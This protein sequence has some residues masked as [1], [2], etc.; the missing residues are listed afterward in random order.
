MAMPI[1][2]LPAGLSSILLQSRVRL[3]APAVLAAVLAGCG[4]DEVVLARVGDA[5]ITE[6]GLER[7]VDR[8]PDHLVSD[9][10]GVEADR[11][12]LES[13]V[14]QELLLLEARN[15]GLDTTTALVRQMEDEERAYLSGRFNSQVI[16]PRIEVGPKEIERAFHDMG[17][18]RERLLQRIVVRGSERDA[19]DVFERLKS[20]ADFAALVREHAANDARIDSTGTIGWVGVPGLKRLRVPQSEFLSLP[21]GTPALLPLSPLVW[22]I[23]RFEQDR[24]VPIQLYDDDVGKLLYRE[25]WWRRTEEEVELLR[26]NQDV[27]FH[28]EG[29]R[30]LIERAEARQPELT[31]EQAGQPLFTWA[32]GNPVTA[33]D[34]V[35]RVRKMARSSAVADSALI[36]SIAERELLYPRL[37]AFEARERGWHEDEAFEEWWSR[38]RAG[39]L[40]DHL[41]KIEVEDRLV[42]SEEDVRAY[43]EANRE[44]FRAAETARIEE[45]HAKDEALAKDW[46]D[47]IEAGT[48]FAEI[49]RRPGTASHGIHKRGG[50]MILQPHL[51]ESFP[52]LVEAAFSAPLGEL[53]GPLYLER[54]DSHAILRVLEREGSR[55]RTFDEARPAV[56]HHLRTKRRDSLV[57]G[58][59]ESLRER[60]GDRIQVFEDRLEQ[61]HAK[62]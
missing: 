23:I 35:D 2:E 61:R 12:H 18:D 5:E 31:P 24:E 40:L 52:E 45:V 57:S 4:P 60:Y 1:P 53:V 26:R 58:L 41:M 50:K 54:V 34:F 51:A 7:F 30:A 56:Q 20:G 43:F 3:L 62:G 22:Q 19:Q 47:E 46:R 6:A 25:Q 38:T 49:L 48:E 42:F 36:R 21:V 9:Q 29:V 59:F 17:F 10:E 44:V 13:M 8:L 14:D 16:A 37:F 32:G 11:D 55:L 33:A 27:R 28:Q 39:I 15:R